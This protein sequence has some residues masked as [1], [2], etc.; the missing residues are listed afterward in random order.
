MA[1][2]I[3]PVKAPCC[4]QWRFWAPRAMLDA[5]SSVVRTDANAVKGGASTISTA[6]LLG[7]ARDNS[8]T[9]P[10]ASEAVLFIFQLPTMRVVRTVAVPPLVFALGQ[11]HQARQWFAFQ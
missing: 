5:G 9:K 6:G 11:G 4:S 1:P 3:S 2:E 8:T 7:M 10:A